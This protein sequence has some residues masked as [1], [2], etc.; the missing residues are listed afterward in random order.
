VDR[1]LD[2]LRLAAP[3]HPSHPSSIDHRSW[4]GISRTIDETDKMIEFG[5][6]SPDRGACR[7]REAN[8]EPD[9]P[10]KPVAG[11]LT[12]IL[13]VFRGRE[14]CPRACVSGGLVARIGR[15]VGA[16]LGRFS[17]PRACCRSSVVE[18]SIGNGEVDSSILSGSTILP[19]GDVDFI[20]TSVL[21]AT[22]TMVSLNCSMSKRARSSILNSRS[23]PCQ[24]RRSATGQARAAEPWQRERP[25]LHQDGDDRE[26]R[27]VQPRNG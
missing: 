18:H 13:V 12:P 16:L 21:S 5:V 19:A 17:Y 24:S 27:F 20:G 10:L 4:N 26:R 11:R 1:P 7:A 9:Q 6:I 15:L 23:R 14:G 25:A 3:A 22:Q 8:R 2:S